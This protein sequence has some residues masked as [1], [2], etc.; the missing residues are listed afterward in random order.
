MR[1]PAG[2]DKTFFGLP[3][4]IQPSVIEFPRVLCSSFAPAGHAPVYLAGNSQTRAAGRDHWKE[5][6]PVLGWIAFVL[7]LYA[8]LDRSI[9]AARVGH[10]PRTNS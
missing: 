9:L 10:L 6:D 4:T 1:L 7:I 2:S 8:M 5:V 3:C